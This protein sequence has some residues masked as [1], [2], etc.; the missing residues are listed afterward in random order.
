MNPHK[1]LQAEIM[2]VDDTAINLKLLSRMLGKNGYTVKTYSSGD[3]AL[4]AASQKPP[5]LIL[6]D[7]DMPGMDGYQMCTR[8]KNDRNLS[9]I[10]VIFLSALDQTLDKV[11]AFSVGGVDYITKPFHFGEIDARVRTHL[12]LRQLQLE[13]ENNNRYLEKQV[14]EKVEEISASQMATIVSLAKLAESRDDVTGRHIERVQIYCKELAER[15]V[16]NSDSAE[17]EE[18]INNIYHASSLHDIGKV[19]IADNIL[20]KPGKLDAEEFN[21]MKEHTIIGARTLQAAIEQNPRNEFLKMG[22]AIAEAHHEKWDG[23][24][25][26]HGLSS[27]GIPLSARIMA[28]ADV[29]DALRS[30]RPYKEPMPHEKAVSIIADGAGSHFDPQV[31]EQFLNH[32]QTFLQISEELGD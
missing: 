7:I 5:D 24:G 29:Y 4:Q 27:A 28:V 20:N 23:S 10:P 32:D 2:I 18:F 26:P 1:H 9:D 30:R 3:Q 15:V 12:K 31:A 17:S 13:L 8:L 21:R 22:I 19:G 6:L 16:G 11:K 14:Q 25:Y